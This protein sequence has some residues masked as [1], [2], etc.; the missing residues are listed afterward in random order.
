M[1]TP[2]SKEMELIHAYGWLMEKF[3][4]MDE[5]GKTRRDYQNALREIGDERHRLHMR[6]RH[7]K[8]RF[9]SSRT[10]GARRGLRGLIN[11]KP[12]PY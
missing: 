8:L 10:E 7:G 3:R 5:H 2:T 4:W 11:T 9:V 1:T 6:S 12:Q